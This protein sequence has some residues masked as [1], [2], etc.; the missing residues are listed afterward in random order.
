VLLSSRA[1][2]QLHLAVW[3]MLL[4][5]FCVSCKP[6]Y[7]QSALVY[8]ISASTAQV[9]YCSSMHDQSPVPRAIYQH[10]EGNRLHAVASY[11][12]KYACIGIILCA[13]IHVQLRVQLMYSCLSSLPLDVQS[14]TGHGHVQSHTGHAT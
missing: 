8:C 11:N 13:V 12:V 14:H 5:V 10:D 7:L 3:L 1:L 9:Q 4:I 6:F 2:Y